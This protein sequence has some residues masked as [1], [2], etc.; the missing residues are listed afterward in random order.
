MK[1]WFN[2]EFTTIDN[3]L[4][5]LTWKEINALIE[6]G[7]IS[8]LIDIALDHKDQVLFKKLTNLLNNAMSKVL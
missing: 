2:G 4:E 5:Y 3:A 7:E 8:R 6:S 1:I